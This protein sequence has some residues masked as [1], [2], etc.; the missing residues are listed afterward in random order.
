V[1]AWI[2]HSAGHQHFQRENGWKEQ[3]GKRTKKEKCAEGDKGWGGA[4][5]VST[6]KRGGESCEKDRKC[7][8]GWSQK[9]KF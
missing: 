2:L 4:G 8:A 1:G 7:E 3:G 9:G 5:G 6:T